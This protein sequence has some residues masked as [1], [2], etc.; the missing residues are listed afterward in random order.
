MQFYL[1]SSPI[2]SNADVAVLLGI[3]HTQSLP[4]KILY[5][6]RAWKC[7]HVY[8]CICM[9]KEI[10]YALH[11]TTDHR[12]TLREMRPNVENRPYQLPKWWVH[13]SGV[14]YP[15][16]AGDPIV[17]ELSE[18]STTSVSILR[19]RQHVQ[20]F[21]GGRELFIPSRYLSGLIPQ[22]LL[23]SYQFWRDESKA[24]SARG[25]PTEISRG[26]MRLT[27]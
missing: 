8:E 14:A 3:H 17:S 16:A 22:A 24:P 4:F 15:T 18:K 2:P 26:Y 10:W 12:Y 27:G 25:L 6:F 19:N 11:L 5:I 13:G 23:D 7:V 9:G 1:P 20:N 21:S